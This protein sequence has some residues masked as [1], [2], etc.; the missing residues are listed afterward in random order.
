MAFRKEICTREVPS[1][2]IQ[3]RVIAWHVF[4]IG[5]YC[6]AA[7]IELSLDFLRAQGFK[8][9]R[10]IY[11]LVGTLWYSGHWRPLESLKMTCKERYEDV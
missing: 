10:Y 8:L 9:Q 5:D 11:L 7:R 6:V 2:C 1:H 3:P 4:A